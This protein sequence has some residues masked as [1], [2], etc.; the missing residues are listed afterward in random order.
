MIEDLREAPTCDG[1]GCDRT[2][3]DPELVFRTGAG[4]RR[5]Y[6]CACGAVTVTVARGESPR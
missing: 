4:E 2:L 1:E 3:T 5:A 6:E